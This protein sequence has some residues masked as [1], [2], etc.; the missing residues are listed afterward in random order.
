[1]TEALNRIE[2]NRF[3]QGIDFVEFD[4]PIKQDKHDG[5]W[6]W[7]CCHGGKAVVLLLIQGQRKLKLMY[8][9]PPRRLSRV[10]PKLD[11][12]EV[13]WFYK[14]TGFALGNKV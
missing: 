2:V 1:M 14:G 5:T 11:L 4:N 12:S 8:L 13:S 10:A 3:T 7:G 9:D 6:V